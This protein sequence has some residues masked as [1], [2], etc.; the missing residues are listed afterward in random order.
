MTRHI[1]TIDVHAIDENVVCY[2]FDEGDRI[3]VL[4]LN[5]REAEEL[6]EMLRKAIFEAR[7]S[8]Y[9]QE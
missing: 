7:K 8:E 3:G 5:V 6:V 4:D 9:Y 1:T 2:L